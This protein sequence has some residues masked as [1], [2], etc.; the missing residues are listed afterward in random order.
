MRLSNRR[1]EPSLSSGARPLDAPDPLLPL[2]IRR[3]HDQ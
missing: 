3:F 1:R 2:S